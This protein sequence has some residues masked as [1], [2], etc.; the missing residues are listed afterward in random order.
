MDEGAKSL[1]GIREEEALLREIE[2]D[3][4]IDVIVL[5]DSDIK[6]EFECRC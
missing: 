5:D 2:G 4:G 3:G 1:I 6:A